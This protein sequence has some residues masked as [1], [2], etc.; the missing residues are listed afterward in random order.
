MKKL[1]KKQLDKIAEKWLYKNGASK[2][3]FKN[4]EIILWDGGL[5]GGEV[6]KKKVPRTKIRLDHIPGSKNSLMVSTKLG[7]MKN[8]YYY[9]GRLWFEDISG[10]VR[11]FKRLERL[12]KSLGYNTDIR[13]QW[14]K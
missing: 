1:N 7:G 10:H 6:K 13:K 4:H 3:D 14:K 8:E 9:D 12:L 11:Y 2:I 5:F